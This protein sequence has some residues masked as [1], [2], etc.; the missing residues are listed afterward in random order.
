MREDQTQLFK[1]PYETLCDTF[2]CGE[3]GEYFVGRPDAPLNTSYVLCQTCTDSLVLSVKGLFD[4]HE[5]SVHAPKH[6]EEVENAVDYELEEVLENIKT[7]AQLDELIAEF[8]VEGVP[9]REEGVKLSE[10]K[11]AVRKL[12][13]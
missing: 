1:M 10:R 2:G 11:D 9:S 3:P 6:E 5:K 8:N 12:F 4:M 7:H 13:K